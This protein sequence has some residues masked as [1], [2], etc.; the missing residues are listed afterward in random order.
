[1]MVFI[2]GI[3]GVGKSY[4][5]KQLSNIFDLK[6][7]SASQIIK[8]S[9]G[10]SDYNKHVKDVA[11]NQT[12]LI[13]GLRSIPRSASYLLDGH[14]CLLNNNTNI[15]KIPIDVFHQI[16]VDACI[17]LS[18]EPYEIQ[19]RLI[20]RD[21]N[22]LSLEQ[23]NSFQEAEHLHGR[24]ICDYLEVPYLALKQ[25]INIELAEVFLSETKGESL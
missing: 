8:Q 25:P 1:M 10:H 16:Q 15:E 13:Y 17:F 21:G 6:V 20:K 11:A 23:I 3:H 22:A 14:F 24:S 5:C 7:L 9:K 12:A 4:F 2:S 19:Q 18:D